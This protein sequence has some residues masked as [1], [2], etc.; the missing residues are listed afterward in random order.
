MLL[1]T[2]PCG[3]ELPTSEFH[4]LKRRSRGF[5]YWC[6]S[7]H[8][9]YHKRWK[10][11]NKE[12]FDGYVKKHLKSNR[13]DLAKRSKTWREENPDKVLAQ[14]AKRRADKKKRTPCWLTKD[15]KDQIA[16]VYALRNKMQATFGLDYEVDH[17]VPLMGENV[18]GLHVPWNLQILEKSLNKS[19]YNKH[20]P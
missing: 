8:R 4:R 9:E 20:G 14:V 11:E 3:R 13:E 7:C 18:C 16:Q 1:C 15:Q 2:G 10:A 19:K 12:K 17:I 5:A 6:K